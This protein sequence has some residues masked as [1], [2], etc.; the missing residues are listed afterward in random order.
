MNI[1]SILAPCMAA[2]ILLLGVPATPAHANG[3]ASTRNIILF[4][5]AAAAATYLIVRHN[6]KVH[7]R[8]A[9]AAARQAE[10][11]QQNNDEASAYAQAHHAYQEELTVNDEL[12]KEATYQHTVV[13][14]QR[15]ELA[16]LGV[17]DDSE[18]SDV[19]MLSYG[20]GTV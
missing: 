6:R 11:E 7:E 2:I 13:E 17:Q 18:A 5:A 16:S 9:A 14:T 12:Q 3:A 10:V 15:Q 8:E 20:W 1:R 4:S 19:D